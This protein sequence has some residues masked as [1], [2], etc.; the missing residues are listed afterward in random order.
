TSGLDNSLTAIGLDRPNQVL[1][2]VYSVS[3][4]PAVW[5][6]PTAFAQNATGTL[7][8]RGRCA[9]HGPGTFNIDLSL[10]RTFHMTERVRLE[11]RAEAFNGLNHVNYNNPTTSFNS[12]NFGKIQGAADP[13]I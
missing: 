1:P 10:S 11:A 6:N 5:L 2:N 9:V 7:G 4:N 3:P 8:N 13:R 12:S